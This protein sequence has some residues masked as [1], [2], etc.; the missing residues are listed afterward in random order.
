MSNQPA[1]RYWTGKL[2]DP[3]QTMIVVRTDAVVVLATDYD[4]DIKA[5]QGKFAEAESSAFAAVFNMDQQTTTLKTMHAA[6][7]Y[8]ID[9]NG[10]RMTSGE[11]ENYNALIEGEPGE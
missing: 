8:L 4:R 10:D 5:L 2:H 11:R 6:L 1:K 3:D 7:D 9:I